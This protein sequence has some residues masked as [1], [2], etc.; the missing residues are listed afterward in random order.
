MIEGDN[1]LLKLDCEGA[2]YDILLT[3]THEEMNRINE[4][5]LEIHTD[6]HP[7]FKGKEILENK[8]K[9]FGFT[10]LKSDQIYYYDIDHLGNKFNWRE[11][12]YCNQRWK[13]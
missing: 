2:E 5:V 6:L 10:N 13:R 12:P 8:L 9:E 11:L 7:K 3:A 1:I 4:V